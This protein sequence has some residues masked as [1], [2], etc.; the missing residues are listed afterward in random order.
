[1]NLF[2]RGPARDRLGW[3]LIVESGDTWF[4]LHCAHS[5]PLKRK[6]PTGI[7]HS[8]FSYFLIFESVLFFESRIKLTGRPHSNVKLLPLV[9]VHFFS[10]CFQKL[11]PRNYLSA[12][13]L[14]IQKA[15]MC[16]IESEA[17]VL[18]LFYNLSPSRAFVSR[19]SEENLRA[20]NE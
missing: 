10:D 20:G 3:R 4:S 6:P 7:F 5:S 12:I 1:M 14:K 16:N 8:H 13:L 17:I 11:P 19:D 9:L 18:F 15:F 2:L